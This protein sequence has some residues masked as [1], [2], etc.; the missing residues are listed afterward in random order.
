MRVRIEFDSRRGRVAFR[1]GVALAAAALAVCVPLYASQVGT[2]ISFSPGQVIKASDFNNNFTALKAAIDDTDN[3]CGNL[4]TLTTTAKGDLVSAVNEVNGKF[5]S[6][7]ILTSVATDASLT[8]NGTATSQLAVNFASGETTYDARYLQLSSTATQMVG[9]GG[10]TLNGLDVQGSATVT[11]QGTNGSSAL[12]SNGGGSTTANAGGTALVA[13]GGSNTGTLNGAGGNA[14]EATGGSPAGSG[15]PGLAALFHGE[16][17]I[18]GTTIPNGPGTTGV[19]SH[20]GLGTQGGSSFLSPPQYGGPGGDLQ[21]GDGG[22]VNAGTGVGG[23][24]GPGVTVT[25][26]NGG[27]GS[28]S[29]VTNDGYGGAGATCQGGDAGGFTNGVG[30]D[31]VTAT[32]GAGSGSGLGGN[33]ITATAGGGTLGVAGLAGKFNG[34]VKITGSISKGS[35][36][37]EIDHP[38]DPDNKFLCHSFVESPDMKN[39]YDGVVVLDEKGEATVELPS[40]FE[41]LNKDFRYQLTCLGGFAPVYV[42]REI[43]EN[44]FSIA[45][46]KPGLKVSWLVTGIRQDA[47]ANAHRVQ[48]E[49]EK[50]SRE[51]GKLLY[52][53]EQGRPESDGISW[54]SIRKARALAAPKVAATQPAATRQ[55]ASRPAS[56][57][58]SAHD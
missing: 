57:A 41:A 10:L 9:P 2:L 20:G 39:I 23:G 28:S 33:G 43:L 30:G 45:G 8:G 32:G 48:V 44:R 51:K 1:C 40:Y 14:I 37:F 5:P 52:P 11:A 53:L 19:R 22:T 58:G 12:V 13:N 46:G 36:T 18:L 47:Y 49:V 27:A 26:G 17:D 56:T 34:N 7:T 3:K 42:S 25:G 38:L 24:G 21:G 15:L 54:D 31:G 16:V 55:V 29:G 6:G 4:T 35:G 50:S